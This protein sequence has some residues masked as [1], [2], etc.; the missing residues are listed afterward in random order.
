MSTATQHPTPAFRPAHEV[1]ATSTSTSAPHTTATLKAKTSIPL[2]QKS[3][4][5]LV[6]RVSVLESS[7]QQSIETIQSKVDELSTHVT[8][9]KQDLKD[10][11]GE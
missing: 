2:I 7:H 5:D 3:I 10:L 1:P 6:N 9:T 4:D 11:I 8:Q